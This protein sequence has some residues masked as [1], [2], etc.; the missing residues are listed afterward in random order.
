MKC[1]HNCDCCEILC[2]DSIKKHNE[3]INNQIEKI[4]SLKKKLEKADALIR[5]VSSR[6]CPSSINEKVDNYLKENEG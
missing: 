6:N 5:Y 3:S 2:A 1:N 4:E